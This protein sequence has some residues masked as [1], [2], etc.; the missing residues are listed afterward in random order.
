MISTVNYGIIIRV[1]GVQVPPPLPF[2]SKSAAA[3]RNANTPLGG[4]PYA[5]PVEWGSGGGS[6]DDLRIVDRAR[7]LRQF[8][9]AAS[10]KCHSEDPGGAPL[11]ARAGLFIRSCAKA[12]AGK[13]D[14]RTTTMSRLD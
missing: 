13:C 4:V 8:S 10:A 2:P 14:R 3:R 6:S 7:E 5:F 9:P 1:S 11:C 12:A